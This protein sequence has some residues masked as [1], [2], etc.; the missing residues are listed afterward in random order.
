MAGFYRREKGRQQTL[1]YSSEAR[2]SYE[3]LRGGI[4]AYYEAKGIPFPEDI[5]EERWRIYKR[6]KRNANL[7]LSFLN[8]PEAELYPQSSYRPNPNVP[9]AYRGKIPLQLAL[10][11]ANQEVLKGVSS[12]RNQTGVALAKD[13]IG[14]YEWLINKNYEVEG[15]P[16]QLFIDYCQAC[17]PGGEW[18]E[19]SF[20]HIFLNN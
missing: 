20:C 10:S 14:C 9:D 7:D 17:A 16:Y 19:L 11:K 3:E 18:N 1:E 5:S 6:M 15:E 2:Y 8:K 4:S 13:L 12:D